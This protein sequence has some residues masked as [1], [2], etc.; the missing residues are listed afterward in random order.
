ME[1]KSFKE[2]FDKMLNN[3]S[4]ENLI[5]DLSGFGCE[6]EDINEHIDYSQYYT[7]NVDC[8]SFTQKK[9]KKEKFTGISND[10]CIEDFCNNM[11]A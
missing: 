11:A 5:E 10:I 7:S 9:T 6:F 4:V 8:I 1:F 2:E 3:L